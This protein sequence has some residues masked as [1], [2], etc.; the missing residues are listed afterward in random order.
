MPPMSNEV[1]LLL[2]A[3]SRPPELTLDVSDAVLALARIPHGVNDWHTR[4]TLLRV[5]DRRRLPARYRPVRFGQV[6]GRKP[7]PS[8][9]DMGRG[10]P[11]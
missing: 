9:S 10:L 6:D 2:D 11:E 7:R 3:A 5:P 8:M 4:A 1:A